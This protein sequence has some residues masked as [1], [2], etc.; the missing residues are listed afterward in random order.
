MAKDLEGCLSQ[1]NSRTSTKFP[2]GTLFNGFEEL[3]KKDEASTVQA[4]GA[5]AAHELIHYKPEQDIYQ[6][7]K[8]TEEGDFD[9]TDVVPGKVFRS[10]VEDTLVAEGNITRRWGLVVGPK[11]FSQDMLPDVDIMIAPNKIPPRLRNVAFAQRYAIT[12][13]ALRSELNQPTDAA[14]QERLRRTLKQISHH[15]AKNNI[16]SNKV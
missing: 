5:A 10:E 12:L 2:E 6:R 4:L 1:P 11:N 15:A 16:L 7:I 14:R 9:I 13:N 3:T 8:L